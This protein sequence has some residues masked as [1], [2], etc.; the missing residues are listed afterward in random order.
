MLSSAS[1]NKI[2][3][4]WIFGHSEDCSACFN[5]D[6]CLCLPMGQTFF[7]FAGAEYWKILARWLEHPFLLQISILK[8]FSKRDIV[9]STDIQVNAD[10]HSSNLTT[11]KREG[12]LNTGTVFSVWKC[13]FSCNSDWRNMILNHKSKSVINWPC[14]IS[15]YM[16]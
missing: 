1:V 11:K 6:C 4:F 9:N 10:S 13:W 7:L 5:Y 3:R 2:F 16:P 15:Y 8:I 14:K 12:W